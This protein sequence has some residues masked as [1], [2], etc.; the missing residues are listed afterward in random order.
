MENM[1][2]TV[3][4]RLRNNYKQYFYYIRRQR[5]TPRK[6]IRLKPTLQFWKVPRVSKYLGFW[7]PT[8][9]ALRMMWFSENQISVISLLTLKTLEQIV[10]VFW[11]SITVPF[12]W[13]ILHSLALYD[14]CVKFSIWSSRS[15]PFL[16][17]YA[18]GSRD[19]M[20]WK[21]LMMEWI[22]Y[23]ILIQL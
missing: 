6:Y 4:S 1:K 2:L 18:L 5:V 16:K 19:F 7:C 23:F 22:K 8:W 14:A 11:L 9:Y 13:K 10:K 3:S 20:S 12:S 17:H 15:L 21:T